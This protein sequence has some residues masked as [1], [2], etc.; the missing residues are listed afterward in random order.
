MTHY[1]F[2]LTTEGV[3]IYEV[4]QVPGLKCPR[5]GESVTLLRCHPYRTSRAG[6]SAW[7]LPCIEKRR[8]WGDKRGKE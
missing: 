2:E 8:A 5:C 1:S 3:D 4:K 7:C 6:G